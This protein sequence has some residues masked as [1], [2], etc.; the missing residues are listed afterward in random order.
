MAYAEYYDATL[1]AWLPLG[2]ASAES[3]MVACSA[4]LTVSTAQVDVPGLT[5]TVN[6]TNTGQ[7]FLIDASLD[8]SQSIAGIPSVTVALQ[9]DGVSHASTI[10]YIGGATAARST[11]AKQWR[12]S[13]LSVGS[14][15]FKLV[16]V[17]NNVNSFTIQATSST[18]TVEN[19]IAA[20]SPGPF[21]SNLYSDTLA[22][23]MAAGT[24]ISPAATVCTSP[25]I[26]F[27]GATKV[28][29]EFNWYNIV[30]SVATDV[31]VV[32]LFDGATQIGSFLLNTQVV[33]GGSGA[34]R[35]ILTPTAGSHTFTA[36]V[37][38]SS[39]TGTAQMAVNSTQP[40]ILSIT[41]RY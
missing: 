20:I 17:A 15:T 8:I 21:A 28:E 26:T 4:G 7:S 33:N 1:A 23:T 10:T 41:P 24:V 3:Y 9:I 39:G 38:R 29:V 18:M 19:N 22:P 13:G 14:H 37:L 31:V 34:V 35:A 5:V 27:D 11:L 12:V 25:A 40:S 36:K 6:V 16:A 2:S 32:Q 30:K